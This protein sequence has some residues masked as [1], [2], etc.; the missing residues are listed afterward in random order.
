VTLVGET[1]TP[2]GYFW[3]NN[4]SNY[5]YRSA[6]PLGQ[7]LDNDGLRMMRQSND[8][9]YEQRLGADLDIDCDNPGHCIIGTW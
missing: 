9:A 3:M 1:D 4:P 7:V 2:K 6:G 8:D 5:T